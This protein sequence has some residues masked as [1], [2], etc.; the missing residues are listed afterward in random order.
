MLA[1][2]MVA[3]GPRPVRGAEGEMS[4]T[5]SYRYLQSLRTDLALDEAGALAGGATFGEHRLRLSSQAYSGSSW[6]AVL[7]AEVAG[8]FH[9]ALGSP[10]PRVATLPEAQRD[11]GVGVL[12][13]QAYVQYAGILG[14]LRV[15]L[16]SSQ[17]GLGMLANNGDDPESFGHGR[18]GDL[19]ARALWGSRPFAYASSAAWA[20]ELTLA[21]AVDRVVRDENASSGDG[22]EAYQG[23]LSVL[24]QRHRR[25]LGAY[26]VQRR[27]RDS[28]GDQLTASV[29]DVFFRY[30]KSFRL[31]GA[32]R[33][34][35]AGAVEL[36]G[37]GAFVTG[38]TDRIIAHNAREGLNVRAAGWVLRGDLEVGPARLRLETGYASGDDN[39]EDGES[40]RFGFDP[41][42]QVGLI[43][44]DE[45][46]ARRS[47]RTTERI[48]DPARAN[49]AP[50]GIDS[51][52]TDGRMTGATYLYPTLRVRPRPWLEASGG[53]LLAWSS[54]ANL[55]P[56]T[57][58]Q[59]GGAPRDGF[60][61]GAPG[62]YLGAEALGGIKLRTDEWLGL[63][64][65]VGM[66]AGVFVPDHP[67]ERRV[68]K[69][70]VS[71]GF[72]R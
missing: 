53:V 50:K 7:E 2:A 51:F 44:F 72:G 45:V 71:A 58:F 4:A 70:V 15:G 22:D 35:D 21:L 54:A 25:A 39:P 6:A 42:Y 33:S 11:G 63:P 9:G 41:D 36:S 55:D 61:R 59:A 34:A 49:R 43:L 17:W 65:G 10:T 62:R 20:Q 13:R 37:E 27:Q 24:W 67:A 28:D 52:V 5:A 19:S 16:M 3:S 1:A 26:L 60:D 38:E 14:L 47:V 29:G 64:F 66:Q 69:V 31:R 18:L 57:T 12:A 40:R 48:A 68:S 30:R 32:P 46:M 8:G 23:V 56:F